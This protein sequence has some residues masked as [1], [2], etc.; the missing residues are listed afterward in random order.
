MSDAA[1]LS[2]F[3]AAAALRSRTLT[4]RALV[5]AVLDR[6]TARK[7]LDAFTHVAADALDQAD[8]ADA[9][10]AAGQDPG[11]FCGLPVA[12][13]DMTDVAGQPATSG[14]AVL[15]GRIADQD[16]PVVARLRAQG[17]VLIGKVATYEF[18]M[19][20]PDLNLPEP[21]ARN[22][23]NLDYTTGGSSSG[24]AVA[25]GG[26]LVRL[27]L[28]TDS[29]GSIRA[30]AA[31]C[32]CVGLKPSYDRVA[33]AGSF[34]LSPALDHTGTLTA[35][36]AEAALA[37]DAITE[38]AEWRPASAD[39]GQGVAG[40]TIGYAR[41]WFATDPKADAAMIDAMDA[42]AATL[43]LLG[44]RITLIDLPEYAPYE[45]AAAVIMHAEALAGHR[46]LIATRASAYGRPT[47][48]CLAFGA[49]ISDADLALARSA[50]APLTEAM[51]AAMEGVD[52][53]MTA[54]TLTTA[55]PFSAFD[56]EKAV[57]TPMRTIAFN[58]TGQ[59]ALS[60]PC[61]FDGGLPLGLQL[62][63]RRGDDDLICRVGHA[64]EQATD[65]SVQRPP[66]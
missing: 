40:L 3:Q 6:I 23:W 2:L 17:A 5:Q 49:A 33:R 1:D 60:L 19:V 32:G 57:W 46:D 44:A 41:D 65:H 61:G 15:A 50:V 63:G 8:A 48:Q 52:L 21:P 11:P 35:S 31:Y 51:L 39:I 20:G 18:G 28:G 10:L 4:S 53:M 30:P 59:P 43:S 16:A 56:G 38:S 24:S 13:K 7:G 25:V 34:L 29:G 45:A 14:S 26:G 42:A 47:L 64:F 36:V 22:P 27:A 54:T 12:V 37:L 66:L 62:I 58:L 55:L 9:M